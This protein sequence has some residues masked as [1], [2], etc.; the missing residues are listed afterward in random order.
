MIQK[1]KNK[2]KITKQTNKIDLKIGPI[3]DKTN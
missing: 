1:I 2:L 3:Q